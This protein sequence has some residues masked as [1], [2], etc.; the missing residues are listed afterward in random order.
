M[1]GKWKVLAAVFSV[2][3]VGAG[4]GFVYH[5]RQAI[6]VETCQTVW[7]SFPQTVMGKGTVVVEETT[8]TASQAGT[9]QELTAVEGKTLHEGDKLLQLDATELTMEWEQAQWEL[10][11][12]RAQWEDGAEKENIQ[13]GQAA[14]A[15]AQ[16]TGYDLESF[17]QIME[18]ANEAPDEELLQRQ[19]QLAEQKVAALEEQ[20][21]AMTL[22]AEET[23]YLYRWMVDE[24]ETVVPGTPL[25]V[26]RE[27]T[28]AI[29][30]RLREEEAAQTAIGQQATITGGL[31]ID[32]ERTGRVSSGIRRIEAVSSLGGVSRAVIRVT[33]SR[34]ALS[35]WSV[36]SQVDV[37]IQ[38]GEARMALAVPL[39]LVQEDEAGTYVWV[40]EDGVAVRR[41]VLWGE[42]YD[43]WAEIV[44]GL[45]KESQ[46]IADPSGI[47]EGQHVYAAY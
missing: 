9:V 21:D 11:Q 29:E 22:Y 47:Q 43:G 39:S 37:E 33:P 23:A 36:G 1:G 25:A 41:E 44:A 7:R 45:D 6:P 28:C 17:Q 18:E 2:I 15:L 5:S 12:Q 24:G 46:L 16:S 42:T 19:L 30:V 4:V 20:I 10:D 35:Q 27:E 13:K 3:F 34:S 32:E 38:I 31:L 26:L 14:L 40:L 8:L